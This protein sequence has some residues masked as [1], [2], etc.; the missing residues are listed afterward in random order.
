MTLHT[1]FWGT[2]V[3]AGGLVKLLTF[4]AMRRR[5]IVAL[6]GMASL[7]VQ[8]NAHIFDWF[9]DT[10][11]VIDGPR[12]LR[13]DGRYLIVS[14][15]T[16]WVDIF[17]VLR[18]FHG[19]APFLRFFLKRELIWL[20]VVG[21]ACWALEFPF[22]RRYTPEYLARYPEKRGRD[23]RT[24]RIACRRYRHIPV[25]ILN[26]V[27]GTR[28]TRRKHDVQDSP[29]RFLLRPRVGGIAF[30]LASLGQELDAMFDTTIVYPRENVSIWH[31]ISN[32]LPSIRVHVREIRIPPEF[33]S[34]AITEP[35]EPRER[36]R[37]WVEEIWKEKD[38]LIAEMRAQS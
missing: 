21:Q 34:A 8:G 12:G 10:R 22:M 38:A 28:Y 11:W 30:V 35:G 37:E 26:F 3:L 23:L 20:P 27:E 33:R 7:W 6:S 13:H 17:A 9:L 36:F 15:H 32:Q 29:Y 5:V 16:S 1:L 19:G 24:T 18:A 2:L 4:G 31:F 14:N 25:S